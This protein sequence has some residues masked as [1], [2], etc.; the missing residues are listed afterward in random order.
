MVLSPRL[1]YS[2]ARTTVLKDPFPKSSQY[3]AEHY[4]TLV[5]YPAPFHKYPEP[6]LCLV[7]ISRYYTLDENTYSQFLRDNNEEMDLLAFIRTADPTKVRIGERQLNED[8]LKLLDTTVGRIVPLLPVAPARAQSELDASVDR[9]FDE[10]GSD[11]EEEP[12][13]SVDGDQSAS[14]LLVS[15]VAEKLKDDYGA[16]GGPSMAGKSR[17]AVQRL[18]A[19]ALLNA[20]VRGRPVSTLS[21]VTSSVSATSEREDEHTTDYVT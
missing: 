19:G 15:E 21:F 11:N 5:A 12:H 10:E 14:T 7:R 17:S 4:A 9:L 1:D 13:D 18:L 3:N 8:E 6:F 2:N 16:L 20:E